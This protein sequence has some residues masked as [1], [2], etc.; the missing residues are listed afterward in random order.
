[1]SPFKFCDHHLRMMNQMVSS[2]MMS[3][4]LSSVRE[5]TSWWD[6]GSWETAYF[7]QVK[8]GRRS[9]PSSAVTVLIRIF[10]VYVSR[11]Y[12]VCAWVVPDSLILITVIAML[13][14][15]CRHLSIS[16]SESTTQRPEESTELTAF[17]FHSICPI[18]TVW[19]NDWAKVLCFSLIRWLRCYY[20]K[21]Y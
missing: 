5:E 18:R 3:L 10:L 4:V 12:L 6:E 11:M 19:L 8:I 15:D 2:G 13:Y 1:M 14:Y 7:R 21:C 9:L 17:L 20:A 16:H